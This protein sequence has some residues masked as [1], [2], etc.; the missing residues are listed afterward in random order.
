MGKMN[1]Q[2]IILGGLLAGVIINVIEWV[3]NGMIFASDWASVMARLN[4]SANF[5]LKQILA[6]NAWG[7]L[8]GIAMVWLY[9][10]IR[11]RFGVGPKTAVLAGAA[12]WFMNYGLGGSFPVVAHWV[13]LGLATVTTLIGL[14][15]AVI[16]AVAGAWIYKEAGQPEAK[17]FSQAAGL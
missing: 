17:H 1:W 13:P 7:F 11:P 6:M 3:T 14:V 8:T 12:M 10:A 5:S 15:E 9:A 4:S 16:A 2:R